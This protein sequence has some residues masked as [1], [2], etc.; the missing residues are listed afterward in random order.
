MNNKKWLKKLLINTIAIPFMLTTPYPSSDTKTSSNLNPSCS[1]IIPDKN[2]QAAINAELRRPSSSFINLQDLKNL[3]QLNAG[4]RNIKDLTGLN[5]ASNLTYLNLTRNN[6][7]SIDL[8]DNVKLSK[9]I[10]SEN[11][12]ASINLSKNNLITEL[13]LDKNSSLN[14]ID[15]SNLNL[16]RKLNISSCALSDINISNLS[17]LTSLNIANNSLSEINLTCNPVLETL[18]FDNNNIS[19]LDLSNNTTINTVHGYNNSVYKVITPDNLNNILFDLNDQI[20]NIDQPISSVSA[21]HVRNP[22]NFNNST[23]PPNNISN[24]GMSSDDII[25]WTSLPDDISQ[26]NFY[27]EHDIIYKSKS[28]GSFSGRIYVNINKL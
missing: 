7:T 17:N 2:L 5:L 22:L 3:T 9:L 8:S 21:T 10:L 1:N 23:I 20:I 28:Y 6:I 15:L 4:Y 19:Y 27:F 16:I 14:K 11:K 18:T 24:N 12:I 13:L 25:L 26:L